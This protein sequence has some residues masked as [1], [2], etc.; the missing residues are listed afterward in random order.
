[1]ID[2]FSETLDALN[3]TYALEDTLNQSPDTTY[4]K[5]TLFSTLSTKGVDTRSLL[6]LDL[7]DNDTIN[8]ASYNTR[9][10]AIMQD[11]PDI[12]QLSKRVGAKLNYNESDKEVLNYFSVI[13]SGGN[14]LAKNKSSSA[15]GKY[16]ILRGTL[17]EK[18]NEL[19]IS[20]AEAKKPA[21]QEKIMNSLLSDY[22]NR[23][24]K[25][26]LPLT[27][28]NLFVI[29]N[30]GQ[31]GGIRV[32]KGTYTD[33]DIGAMRVNLHSEDRKGT[34]EQIVQ[35]YAEKYNINIPGKQES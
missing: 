8:L 24:N 27:K 5:D 7:F 17:V 32:L 2:I 25:F 18:A 33:S 28:E 22:K 29:H 19:N 11:N 3:A 6:D 4:S 21:G 14:Y 16:Q 20:I 13:E 12:Y 15:F 10:N 26:D 34:K 30:L 35:K 31:T 23:L 1:M 9:K